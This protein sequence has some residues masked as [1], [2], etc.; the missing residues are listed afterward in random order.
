MKNCFGYVAGTNKAKLHLVAFTRR[1]F[2]HA[3]LDIYR[4]RVPNLHIGDALYV[5]EGD[6]PTHGRVRPL[7]KVVAGTDG[8]AVDAV[9]AGMMGLDPMDVRLFQKAAEL[10]G[11]GHTPLGHY[12]PGEVRVL[13][14]EGRPT[15][16]PPIPDFIL[17]RTLKEVGASL[18][19]QAQILTSLGNIRP[20]VKDDRASSAAT[21][22]RTA[23]PGPS[24]WI[25]TRWWTPP[26]AS[27]FCRAELC[28]S[29]T[30]RR[31]EWEQRPWPQAKP[32][33][34]EESRPGNRGSPARCA[35]A[36][37]GS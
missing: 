28:G 1:N 35:S 37:A 4:I 24:P 2:A 30:R 12:H 25:P 15:E 8:L 9:L 5:M 18:Q 14:G 16:V 33:R 21:A 13:D 11:Q 20:Q 36:A 29:Q 3:L 26:S 10:E 19:E 27:C 32:T 23:R 7:G 22:P 17:P 31:P 6:G 34:R